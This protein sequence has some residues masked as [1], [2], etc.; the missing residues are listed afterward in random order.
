MYSFPVESQILGPLARMKHIGGSVCRRWLWTPPGVT[1]IDRCMKSLKDKARLL[2]PRSSLLTE[3][4][5]RSRRSCLTHPHDETDDSFQPRRLLDVN[6]I[7]LRG[8]TQPS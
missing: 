5:G 7:I 6:G 2:F 1:S 3:D 8:R 4:Q